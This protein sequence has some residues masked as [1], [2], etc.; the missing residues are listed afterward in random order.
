MFGPG[1]RTLSDKVVCICD[2][3]CSDAF[4]RVIRLFEMT[5][6]SIV[7]LSLV[8]HDRVI[9]LVLGLSHIINV[10]FIRALMQ[11]GF[12]YRELKRVAST[13]FLSQMI[14][15]GSVI[16]ED[17]HLYYAIQRLNPFRDELYKN[18][19]STVDRISESVLQGR[20]EEFISILN[21]GRK[22]TEGV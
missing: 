21:N 8:D 2:C 4:T 7:H 6:A 9:S 10:V 18:L 17:P 5:A 3:G 14:T 16:K 15:A 22:W 11:G 12:E 13:T 1:A 20:E 19:K